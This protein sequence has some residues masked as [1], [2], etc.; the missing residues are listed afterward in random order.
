MPVLAQ[1]PFLQ[2]HAL[3]GSKTSASPD[4]SHRY[5]YTEAS[6]SCRYPTTLPNINPFRNGILEQEKSTE[7]LWNTRRRHY[8]C[9]QDAEHAREPF[10]SLLTKCP[11]LSKTFLASLHGLAVRR[12]D[13]AEG[14]SSLPQIGSFFPQHPAIALAPTTCGSSGRLSRLPRHYSGMQL[15]TNVQPMAS[16]TAR[17]S[18]LSC[19]LYL[20]SRTCLRQR[21]DALP[22]A[23]DC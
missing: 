15:K 19:V 23:A 8:S 14:K 5:P 22:A 7:Y 21:G 6:R 16:A 9:C 3:T 12:G 18:E 13:E 11:T 20:C 2:S 10:L 4:S 1:Q 17:K